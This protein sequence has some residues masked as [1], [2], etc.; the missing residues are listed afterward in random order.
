MSKGLALERI[1]S[2]AERGEEI[3]TYLEESVH[4]GEGEEI[5]TFEVVM[6]QDKSLKTRTC[7]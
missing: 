1:L 3:P 2:T 7:G 4:G 6:G 5:L